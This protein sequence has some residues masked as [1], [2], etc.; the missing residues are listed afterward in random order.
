MEGLIAYIKTSLRTPPAP[1]P[2]QEEHIWVP[3][4]FVQ[5]DGPE[6]VESV[7]K[8]GASGVVTVV[9][10]RIECSLLLD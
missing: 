3:C 4:S 1:R 10:V 6:A 9:R 5:P 7:G 2:S 8:D